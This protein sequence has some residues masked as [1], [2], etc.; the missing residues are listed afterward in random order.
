M[1]FLEILMGYISKI[2]IVIWVEM[3]VYVN[4]KIKGMAKK[5]VQKI[6]ESMGH[7]YSSF[8]KNTDILVT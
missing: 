1:D 6:V 8:T 2:Y 5:D 3:K 4:G 7:E